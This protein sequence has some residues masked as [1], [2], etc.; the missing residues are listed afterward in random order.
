MA[1]PLVTP[2]AVPAPGNYGK[3]A[4]AGVGN[5]LGAAIV[6]TL[7]QLTG[8]DAGPMTVI[9]IMMAANM[10]AVFLSKHGWIA[11]GASAPA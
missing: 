9:A 3:L 10:L 6:E 5:V 7:G 1:D 2:A 4:G 8:H 11:L